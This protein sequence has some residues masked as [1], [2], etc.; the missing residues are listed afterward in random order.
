MNWLGSTPV[1]SIFVNLINQKPAIRND[2]DR[3]ID[4]SVE[5]DQ[6]ITV[7]QGW[8]QHSLY[9]GNYEGIVCKFSKERKKATNES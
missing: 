6:T 5:T 3:R 7:F 4:G 8:I 1:A 9:M 2:V